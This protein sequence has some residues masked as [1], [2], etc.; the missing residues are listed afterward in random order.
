MTRLA[1]YFCCANWL[2]ATTSN[3]E[4]E[5]SPKWRCWWVAAK[6]F[7]NERLSIGMLISNPLENWKR[8]IMLLDRWRGCGRELENFGYSRVE[9]DSRKYLV[10]HERRV[11]Q[12]FENLNRISYRAFA[13]CPSKYFLTFWKT[14]IIKHLISN[15]VRCLEARIGRSAEAKVTFVQCC[16]MSVSL[17]FRRS[18]EVTGETQH[19][20]FATL[21]AQRFQWQTKQTSSPVVIS[22][23]G[24]WYTR[25]SRRV[26][27]TMSTA[28]TRRTFTHTSVKG[29]SDTVWM[30]CCAWTRQGHS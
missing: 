16:Q 18:Q 29:H 23:L 27:N 9:L 30:R 2:Y 6:F 13:E 17:L 8:K 1:R 14:I 15:G 7:S 25:V 10:T 24:L 20:Y 4:S 11:C 19:L 22:K 5:R 12:N 3:L 26:K 28:T 21:I